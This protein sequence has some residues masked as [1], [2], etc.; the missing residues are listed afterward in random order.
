MRTNHAE[1]RLQVHAVSANDNTK[2]DRSADAAPGSTPGATI[3]AA[4]PGYTIMASTAENL[5]DAAFILEIQAA[6]SFNAEAS[7]PLASGAF[8]NHA[9]ANPLHTARS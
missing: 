1:Q 2:A 9:A 3:D 4:G 7:A 6:A 8:A 5:S